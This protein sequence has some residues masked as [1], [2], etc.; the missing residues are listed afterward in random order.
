MEIRSLSKMESE[1]FNAR[2]WKIA[3][4]IPAGRVF[5]YGQIAALVPPP[6][7]VAI[8]T[9]LAFRARWVGAAMADCPSDVPWQRVINSQGKI[10]SRPGASQQRQLLE[11]EGVIF[12]ERERV[13]LKRFGWEGPSDAWLQTAGLNR[14]G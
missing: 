12:D 11:S 8:E 10:S 13:D 3:R 7:G 2:V 14:A 9:Y 4:E 1:R 6:S 5:T